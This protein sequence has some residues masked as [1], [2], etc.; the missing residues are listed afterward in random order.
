[1]VWRPPFVRIVVPFV[2]SIR[3]AEG[4]HRAAVTVLSLGKRASSRHEGEVL[5][6][7]DVD[8]RIVYQPPARARLRWVLGGGGLLLGA[9]AT[10]AAVHGDLAAPV[11]LFAGIASV[12][13]GLGGSAWMAPRLCESTLHD[14]VTALAGE[15]MPAAPP[16]R[17]SSPPAPAERV[18]QI[19]DLASDAFRRSSSDPRVAVHVARQCVEAILLQIHEDD[20]GPPDRRA[21]CDVLVRALSE[22]GLLPNRIQVP[23]TTVQVYG[24]RA[25]HPADTEPWTAWDAW[26]A[27]AALV[28]VLRWYFDERLATG[29]PDS[30]RLAV[31]DVSRAGIRA[32]GGAR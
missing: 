30:V 23:F 22:R 15:A 4:E 28:A 2:P 17:R 25:S 13:G 5:A 7:L 14:S 8:L 31:E 12:G 21:T 6:Q 20:L 3:L 18:A 27:M 16:K 10:V 32:A 1:V 11:G 26:P 29:M 9:C 19:A 24:N